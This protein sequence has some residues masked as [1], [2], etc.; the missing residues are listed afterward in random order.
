M[1]PDRALAASLQEQLD[2]E[3]GLAASG[4]VFPHG[5][6]DMGL[7]RGH[8]NLGTSHE[9][10][11]FA[12]DSMLWYWNRIG[13]QCYSWASSLLLLCDCGGSNAANTYIF[14]HDLQTLADTIGLE[15]RV[16]HYPSYCSKYNPIERRL[17][18]HITRACSG[19]GCFLTRWKPL[20]D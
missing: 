15:I 1:R 14:K 20:S 18:P 10:S 12:C 19:A 9:T 6:Y 13:Q 7:N 16:A 2:L 11:Q 17:F 5:L 3:K 8:I 4:A